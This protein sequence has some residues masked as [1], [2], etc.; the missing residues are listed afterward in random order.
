MYWAGNDIYF[1][2]MRSSNVTLMRRLVVRAT[3]VLAMGL[4][5]SI[6]A[7]EGRAALESWKEGEL[8]IHYI[9]TGTGETT[10]FLMPDGTTMLLDTGHHGREMN[11]KSAKA[12]P[13]DQREAGEWVARYI[14]D[15]FAG[16]VEKLDYVMASHFDHDH[17]GAVLESSKPAA[18]GD[19][20]LTG[21][22]EV[23]EFI[24]A[25][26]IID[27][28][29]P[30]YDYP[31]P[32]NAKHIVNYRKF[33][34]HQVKHNGV[35]AEKFQPGRVDQITLTKK[36]QG[37][38]HF[39]IQNLACNGEVWTGEGTNTKHHFPELS[40][41]KGKALPSE[42][43]SSISF[44][45]TYGKFDYFTG[46]DTLGVLV[47]KMPEWYDLETPLAKVTGPVEV[48]KLNHHG[49]R[50]AQNEFFLK[51]LAPRVNVILSWDNN[52]PHVEAF[53]RMLSE[54]TYAGP[55]DFFITNLVDS[56]RDLLGAELSGQ[57]KST[58][59]H[60]VIRVAADGGSFVIYVLNDQS[61]E[62]YVKASFG[63]YECR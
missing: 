32:L 7:A 12:V 56:A 52:H 60:I 34:E 20:V 8:D 41:L 15:V 5:T 44:K 43:G 63:P 62:R 1:I 45:L 42:N 49:Y 6:F 47:G 28:A 50:D 24:P 38:P 48:L 33:V 3:C 2:F 30:T 10:F 27:R 40:S 61:E 46:G 39:K 51:T 23:V 54:E 19:Y 37:Y 36:P 53:P 57:F 14:K 21:L 35:K 59:G 17:I 55:R 31:K 22:S 25:G 29:Y 11:E 18:K 58:Q 9:N 26:K 4:A 13:N 16:K